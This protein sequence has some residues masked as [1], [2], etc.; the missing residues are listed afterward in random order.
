MAIQLKIARVQAMF[1][2]EC[3]EAA[4][5]LRPT[6]DMYHSQI[7]AIQAR[8]AA[9]WNIYS[10]QRQKAEREVQAVVAGFNVQIHYLALKNTTA[11]SFL[12][13]IRHLPVEMLAEVFYWAICGN[14]HPPL[15]LARV[16]RSW[17]AVVFSLSRMWSAVHFATWTKVE[18]IDFILERTGGALLDVDMDMAAD[19][20]KVVGEKEVRYASMERTLSVACRWRSLIITTFPSKVDVD[21]HWA[22]KKST[23]TIGG[24]IN[25]LESFKIKNHCEDSSL[26]EQLLNAIGNGSHERLVDMELRSLNAIYHLAR[27]QFTSIFRRLVTFKVDVHEMRTEVYILAHFEHLEVFEASRL[28]LPTYAL[29]T[30]LPLVR[31]LKRMKIKTVSVQWMVGRT[32]PNLVDCTIISPHYPETLAPGGG[33]HLPICTHFAYD[34]YIIDTLPSFHVPKLDTLNVKNEAWNK[35]RGSTQLAAIWKGGSGQVSPLN[36]RVLHLETQCNDQHLINALS[37]LPELEEL[38]LGVISPDGL[39][40]KFFGA[41]QADKGKAAGHAGRISVLCP[42]LR[43]FGIRYRRWLHD[44]EADEIT[45]MLYNIVKSRWKA[46]APLESLKFWPTKEMPE[47]SFRDLCDHPTETYLED[48]SDWIVIMGCVHTWSVRSVSSPEERGKPEV[49]DPPS[50]GASGRSVACPWPLLAGVT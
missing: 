28:R 33:V 43:T 45:P 17:R 26:F 37:M 12:A 32:F 3:E 44:D 36:P 7:M 10:E 2:V 49:N 23:F 4:G 9:L 47:D 19:I 13:P 46:G 15:A 50:G 6:M 20:H 1:E 31:T 41:L 35:P 42:D 5:K 21:A 25:A 8:M 14:G 30:E 39:G 27:S 22:L 18:K 34:D 29:D 38:Y 40:K 11:A 48:G 16:N 24:P